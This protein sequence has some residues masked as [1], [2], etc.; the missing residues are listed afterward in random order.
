MAEMKW[1]AEYVTPK[2][3]VAMLH[4]LILADVPAILVGPPGI[5]KSAIAKSLVKLVKRNGKPRF[6]YA[7]VLNI[8]Y[9]KPT[10]VGGMGMV[11]EK[12]IKVGGKAATVTVAKYVPPDLI[13]AGDEGEDVLIIWDDVSSA[14]PAVQAAFLEVLH[15]KMVG[16]YPLPKGTYQ[17]GTANR[18]SDHIAAFEIS[19]AML[20]RG[21]VV[22]MRPDA[23]D[24]R[25]YMLVNG[26]DAR[27]PG[28][29][30]M[31]PNAAFS[32]DP[33]TDGGRNFPTGRTWEN[34]NKAIAAGFDPA[35]DS[36]ALPLCASMVGPGAAAEFVAFAQTYGN[37]PDPEQVFQGKNVDAPTDPASAYAWATALSAKAAA[38]KSVVAG[39]RRLARYAMD[40]MK[41]EYS[42]LAVR[43]LL[44]H[45]VIQSSPKMASLIDQIVASPEMSEF[46]D[47]V[48][49]ILAGQ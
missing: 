34:V 7:L 9:R 46:V 4:R 25:E 33:R 41:G 18:A 17:I 13:P 39:A 19:A 26:W 47:K 32:F 30:A 45:P 10:F 11:M 35:A 48:G 24:L 23:D 21:A 38:Q 28:Y 16:S 43:D 6:R 2:Q 29:L 8:S 42:M 44:L 3:A 49:P 14:P 37:L 27:I 36:L 12:K 1:P 22:G 31:R 5:G 20:S 15:E 40:K